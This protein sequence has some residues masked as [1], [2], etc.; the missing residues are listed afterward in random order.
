MNTN[1]HTQPQANYIAVG[2]AL[3]V[4]TFLEVAAVYLPVATV[5]FL[6]LFGA[7]KA[8]LIAMYFMHL[9]VDRRIFTGIFAIGALGG[10]AMV[11]SLI[12]VLTSHLQ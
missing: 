12:I 2:A 1:T 4:L 3:I 7:C 6:I 8:L 10:I 11:A 5:F 9:K